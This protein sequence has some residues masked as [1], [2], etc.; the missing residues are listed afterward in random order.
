VTYNGAMPFVFLLL[1]AL[2]SFQSAWPAPPED[3]IRNRDWL[4]AYAYGSLLIPVAMLAG[5]WAFSVWRVERFR[6]ALMRRPEEHGKLW[7]Q[8]H[9]DNRRQILLLTGCYLA[10]LFG[11][12][13]G[14]SV[15][16][17]TRGWGVAWMNQFVLFGPFFVG[18]VLCWLQFYRAEKAS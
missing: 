17:C 8:F 10:V 18:L 6:G 2:V 11:A 13:W 16:A 9:R 3:I 5:F 1:F 4:T 14:W 12:G 7:R 15:E